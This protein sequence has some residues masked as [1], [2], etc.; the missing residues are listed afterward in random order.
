MHYFTK[1]N[2]RII[3][4]VLAAAML[5]TMLAGCFGSKGSDDTTPGTEGNVPPGLVEV[6]PTETTPPETTAPVVDPNA[7]TAV[8]TVDQ[9]TV[10]SSPSVSNNP[11]GYLDKGDIVN[12]RK[13]V[14][15]LD[16]NWA[17]TDT[18]W[19]VA[20]YLDFNFDPD[21][22][23]TDTPAATDPSEPEEQDSTTSVKGVVT[24]TELYIRKEAD[25]KSTS[26]GSY[27]K[28]DVVTILETKNGW[29]RT[30]QGWISMKYVKTE[31]DST[32][33]DNATDNK[34]DI[35]TDNKTDNTPGTTTNIKGV[36]TASELNIRKEI[37][38]DRVGGYVCG[39]RITIL[40]TKN[41]WGRT[42]KGWVSMSYVYQDGTTGKN[43]AKGIVNGTQLNVRSG[44]GVKYDRVE[45]LK[46]GD[47]VNILEQITIG[48]ETWACTKDGWISMEFIYVDGTKGE[49]AG[50][51]T[52]N[53][54]N[55]NIRSG[56]GTNYDS[57]ASV[58]SGETIE[59]LAI[60]KIGEKH[61]GCTAKGWICMDYVTMG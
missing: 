15:S 57:K 6:K 19:V 21:F 3:T 54:D 17:L 46:Y 53:G 32:K 4:I 8:V 29:G 34:T 56:P 30:N 52:V 18:G 12:I 51:G 55:V 31:G 14:H 16:I 28:G 25:G 20:D 26:L 23:N 41:G 43:T 37:E 39:D 50:T 61:W 5:M 36:V 47:R 38:G 9:L 10:R 60:F 13:T 48:D 27:V 44:P 49:G 22:N 33:E 11:I 7:K 2:S 58:N 35:K 40:E 1:R 42:D 59:I 45:S 24:A